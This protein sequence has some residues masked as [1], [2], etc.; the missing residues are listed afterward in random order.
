MSRIHGSGDEVSGDALSAYE[1]EFASRQPFEACS[2]V[3]RDG[4]R[5]RI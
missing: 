3:R 1:A 4:L 2:D 5:G